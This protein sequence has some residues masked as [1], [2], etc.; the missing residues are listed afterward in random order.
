MIE[1]ESRSNYYKNFLR[2]VQNLPSIPYMMIEVTK[3]LDNPRTSASELG[4]VISRDQGLV[5]K[6]LTVA[7][8]PLYGLPRR[9]STI[10]FAIVILG[11][12]HIKNI[13]I[14]LSM[15]EAFKNVD[16]K[17][18]N[19]KTFWIH[20]LVTAAAAKRI[21][22]DI[23]YP[24]S[25]EAFTAGLLHDLGISVIQR[26]FKD[27]FISICDLSENQKMSFV[28]AEYEILGITHQEIGNF[29]AEKW[30]LPKILSDS[31]LNHHEPSKNNSNNV[32]SA[33]VHL[34]D[35]MT[36]KFGIGNFSWDENYALDEGIIPILKLGNLDYLN[37]F[38][39]SYETLFK[40][41]IESL[42]I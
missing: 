26:Y 38:I 16:E 12:D 41:Q 19:R 3:L 20:S 30:N 10:E 5:A 42:K 37:K 1:V 9:V 15:I 25:G 18:W 31:M 24:K 32:L 23:G 34:A 27:E 22:D 14:A 7:N 36:Q 13:V 39:D 40:H 4:F 21:A 11:F 33:I 35:F 29:L 2:N 6:I 17:K 28:E 8:S